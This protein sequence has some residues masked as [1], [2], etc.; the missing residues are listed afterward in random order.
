MRPVAGVVMALL[1][2]A[3]GSE[4]GPPTPEPTHPA[5]LVAS[6]WQLV[7]ING[8]AIPPAMPVVLRFGPDDLRGDAPCNAYGAGYVYD[9]TTGGIRIE[10]IASTKRACLDQQ[11]ATIEAGY[12]GE[13]Q[14]ASVVTLDAGDVL[15]LTGPAAQLA[16]SRWTQPAESQAGPS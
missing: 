8:R 16:F 4:P 13:L 2:V 5:A 7:S 9:P 12:L 3:C 11:S 1:L 15:F 10:P 6:S 14:A